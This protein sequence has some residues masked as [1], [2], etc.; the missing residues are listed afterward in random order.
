MREMFTIFMS[1]CHNIYFAEKKI[2]VVLRHEAHIMDNSDFEKM[3]KIM[4][5]G[6]LLGLL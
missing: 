4:A 5:L 1:K 3:S 6:F 2:S